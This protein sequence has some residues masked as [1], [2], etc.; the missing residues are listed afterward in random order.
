MPKIQFKIFNLKFKIRKGYTLI[1]FLVVISILGL[2][3]G[4]VLM[5]LTSTLKGANQANVTSEV[6]QNGQAVLDNLQSQIRSSTRADVFVSTQLPSPGNYGLFLT[7]SPGEQLN[8]VCVNST[9]TANGYIEISKQ[10]SGTLPD[11]EASNYQPITNTN[12]ISGV[13]VVCTANT[14]Q[15]NS[16][17][18]LVIID[19]TV[20]QGKQAPSRADFLANARFKTTMAL[21]SY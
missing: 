8:V 6:K 9:A 21:R 12:P 7:L 3:V 2:S 1:E 11:G 18:N 20:N 5:F 16:N 4:S 15:V 10:E 19:F 17:K 13:D 14:F